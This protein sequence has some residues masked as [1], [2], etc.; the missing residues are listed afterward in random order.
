MK[1]W[2]CGPTYQAYSQ[3]AA[4]ERCI[5]LF[6]QTMERPGAKSQLVL[7][8]T[9][10]L[11]SFATITDAPVRGLYAQDGRLFAVAGVKLVEVLAN[12]TSSE[13]GTVAASS[14]PAVF[15]SNGAR[16][17]QLMVVS[18]GKGYIYNLSTGVFAQITDA[19]FSNGSIGCGYIDGYFINVTSDRFQISD[20]LDGTAWGADV[21]QRAGASEAIRGFIVDHELAWLIGH[22]RTEVLYD[23]GNASFPFEPVPGVFLEYGLGAAYALC[24]LGDSI[25]WLVEDERG[26]RQVVRNQGYNAVPI[27]NAA[28]DAMLTALS[29][30]T[31]A[32]MF[33]YQ[34]L[35][36]TFAVLTIPSQRLTLQYDAKESLWS[37][38]AYWNA[39]TG[40]YEAHRAGCH[41]YAFG[42]HLVG[43][44]ETGAIHELAMDAY[45]DAGELIR[46]VRRSPHIQVENRMLFHHE[47]EIAAEMGI[48]LASNEAQGHDPE[49]MM[50]F[51]DDGGYTWSVEQRA[52]LGKLG[53]FEN[54][55]RFFMLGSSRNRVYEIAVS[56]PVKV[57]LI[58]GYLSVSEG[59]H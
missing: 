28:I 16:G 59:I 5:N 45:D 34:L 17:N 51:S 49:L 39:D 42:K 44:R 12:G 46:R 31:D 24:R 9:P 38:M 8:N 41:A 29:S 35:G 32:R 40:L 14:D 2:L 57:V 56:D 4:A 1:G 52:K 36:H 54:R 20:L 15:A 7:L 10:G 11:R 18:G 22:L 43:D 55:A 21:F 53:V 48:G 19:Q 23:S 33:S 13:L 50:R 6:P 3:N 27:S 30:V 26:G 37:E 47:L 25:A 58:D